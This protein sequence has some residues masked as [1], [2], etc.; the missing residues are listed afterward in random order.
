[1]K[2]TT[3]TLPEDLEALV[4][5][6]ADRRGTSISEVIRES[7]AAALLGEMRDIPWAGICDDP[8]LTSGSRLEDALSSWP[9]DLDR[10]RR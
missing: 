6:E 3:I 1:M 2:R 9:D 8:K 7:V 5:Y 10:R 4:R